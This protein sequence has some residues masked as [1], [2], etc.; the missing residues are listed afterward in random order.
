[1]MTKHPHISA[2]TFDDI[3]SDALVRP[4]QPSNLG[5]GNQKGRNGP[6]ANGPIPPASGDP[7]SCRGAQSKRGGRGPM[8]G[9]LIPQALRALSFTGID[10]CIHRE[11]KVCARSAQLLRMERRRG[12]EEESDEE[13][14][15]RAFEA[16][17]PDTCAGKARACE[18]QGRA[19]NPACSEGCQGNGPFPPDDI[20]LLHTRRPVDRYRTEGLRSTA[21]AGRSLGCRP[22]HGRKER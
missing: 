19:A 15:C 10:G 4:Y 7:P 11:S 16:G 2:A 17:G 21:G 14:D 3:A 6:R 20:H 22:V 13:A 9:F 5:T 1:M 12:E 18:A 8:P